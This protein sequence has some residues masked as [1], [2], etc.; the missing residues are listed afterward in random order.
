MYL[1]VQNMARPVAPGPVTVTNG[2]EIKLMWTVGTRTVSNVLHAT[3]TFGD[4]VPGGL[5]ETLFSGF[6][7]ALTSSAFGA[8]LATT[9]SFTGVQV[10]SLN[11]ANLGW[12]LSTGAAQAGTGTGAAVSNNVALVVTLATARSGPSYRGRAY[13]AGMVVTSLATAL[14]FTALVGTHAAAF[15]TSVI[16]TM[17]TNGLTAAVLQHHLLPEPGATQPPMNQERPAGMTPITQARIVN[18]RIDTQRRRLGH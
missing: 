12:I 16:S 9:T 7:S 8:D 11:S 10:K 5:P 1:G 14:Q 15:M 17:G 2:V 6:K 4:N 3:S 13:L 18:P